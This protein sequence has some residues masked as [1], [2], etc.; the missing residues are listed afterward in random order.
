MEDIRRQHG[1]DGATVGLCHGCFDILHEGH[2]HHL[3]QAAALVDIL[4]VSLT[5][6]QYINKG[7]DRPVF[8]DR[9]RLS[10]VAALEFVDYAVLNDT[11]TAVPLVQRLRPDFYVKGADYGAGDDPRLVE[12]REAALAAGGQF[13]TTDDQVFDSSTRAARALHLAAGAR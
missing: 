1:R 7:P 9:A 6:A 2:L 3:Q 8:G 10:V 13:L 5:P 12:E 4:I 11:P